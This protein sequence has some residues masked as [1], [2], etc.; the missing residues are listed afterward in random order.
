MIVIKITFIFLLMRVKCSLPALSAQLPEKWTSLTSHRMIAW[1]IILNF[2]LHNV[3]AHKMPFYPESLFHA[4]L[5]VAVFN[6]WGGRLKNTL[7]GHRNRGHASIMSEH[8]EL[9]EK[10]ARQDAKWEAEENFLTFNVNNLK[11]TYFLGLLLRSS[12]V[13][14][15]KLLVL[16]LPFLDF[17]C[18]IMNHDTL[19][20]TLQVTLQ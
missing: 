6:E 5:L 13:F 14:C 11:A 12:W 19:C 7:R 4:V 20:L 10:N 9:P 8:R 3:F 17:A 1:L 15:P 18:Y 2:L 16:L